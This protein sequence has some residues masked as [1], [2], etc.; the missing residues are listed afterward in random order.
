MINRLLGALSS[1]VSAADL[2]VKSEETLSLSLDEHGVHSAVLARSQGV[3]LRVDYQA[4]LVGLGAVVEPAAGEAAPPFRVHV[5]GTALPTHLEIEALVAEVDRRLSAPPAD[6]APPAGTAKVCFRP[7]AV[8]TLLRPL[9]AA[10]Q[11]RAFFAGASPLSGK[12]DQP[13]L[14]E[15]LTLTDDPLA[16]GRPGS[17]PV[18]DEGVPARRNVLIDHGRLAG[19]IA[20]LTVGASFGVPSTGHS[21]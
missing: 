13:V 2:V 6:A 3:Q 17:R 8:A 11:G 14:D 16:P 1:R 21:W 18:D 10:L 15:R 4:D 5:A 20:D 12:L 9:R 7:R 19:A